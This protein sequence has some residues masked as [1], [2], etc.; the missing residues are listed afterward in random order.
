MAK[1]RKSFS[2]KDVQP[3]ANAGFSNEKP[4]NAGETI[5]SKFECVK[6]TDKKKDKNGI[7][8]IYVIIVI[9]AEL[10]PVSKVFNASDLLGLDVHPCVQNGDNWEVDDAG[11]VVNWTED[12]FTFVKK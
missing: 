12:G 9:Q 10:M 7:E 6:V 5:G 2:A 1:E 3:R 11:Y 4:A 8:H